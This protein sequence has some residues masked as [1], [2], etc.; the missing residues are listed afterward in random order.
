MSIFQT[1]LRLI[2]V[3]KPFFHMCILSCYLS[4]FL[5][6]I[7]TLKLLQKKIF[8]TFTIVSLQD[9]EKWYFTACSKCQLEVFNVGNRFKCERCNRRSPVAYKRLSSVIL[10]GA[11]N[12]FLSFI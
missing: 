6:S 7:L 10:P 12:C 5:T 2:F 9:T 8:S 1:K 3:I 4:K 11:F